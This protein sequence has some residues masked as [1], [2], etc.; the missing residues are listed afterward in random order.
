MKPIQLISPV[1]GSVYAE[2]MP[3]TQAEALAKAARAKAAQKP[4]A[5]RPLEERIAL[6]QAGVAKLNAMAEMIVPEIAWQMGRPTRFGG[7]F[8][9]VNARTEYMS[10]IAAATLAPKMIEDSDKFRRFIA[11]T[12]LGVVFIVAPWNYPYLTTI[13][14]LVPA[15]IAGNSVVLKHASQTMLVG[16]RLAEAFHAAGVPEDVFQN[17]VLDHA[18]T[19]HLIASRAFG[20]VN[21]TGSV[22]GGAAMERAAAGTFTPLGLELGGKDPGYVRAD[23]NLDAAIDT[24]MDGAM[25]N[26]GQCCCGIERIYVHESLYDRFVEGAVKWVSAL[27][28]GN[29][30]DP[31]TT[32][33]P[34]ANKRFAALVRG[35]IAEAIAAG[36]KPLIDPALFPADDGG[37]YLAPQ[38]LVNVDH[39]M[40]VMMEESFGPVVGI[41]KVKD[42]AEA[43]ALMNDS[44][45]GLTASVWTEDYATGHAIGEEIETGTVFMNRADYL[46]PALCW[47]GCK[48]T[49]RGGSLSYLG[50]HSVTRPKSYHLKKV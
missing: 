25:Y 41:M 22:G 13:N 23:A 31:E 36:A 9:G 14:T 37:A 46:D 27:K 24:L 12:P 15:L 5:A 29:P 35:Q 50:F 19:E 28:L 3:L 32:L 16:E 8:G 20:F 48:D 47:T 4:W 21:F 6:V 45:Y 34:M 44:P 1:D 39:S 38:V 33:G 30:F 18:T 26:A 49:G 10:Q 11:R 43:I 7:E 2:R 17:V 40:R 42:D